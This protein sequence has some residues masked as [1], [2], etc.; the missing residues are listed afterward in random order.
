MRLT[1]ILLFIGCLQVSA[2]VLAQTI[3]LSEK[4]TPLQKVFKHIEQQSGYVFFFDY[5][6]LDKARPVTLVIKNIP[7]TTAL[8]LVFSNQPLKYSIAGKNIVVQLKAAPP[9]KPGS[10]T[11]PPAKPSGINVHGHVMD[12]LA[13]P[14]A[15]ASVSVIGGGGTAGGGAKGGGS[16]KGG[17]GA[18]AWG[19][20]ASTDEN[21]DFT[22]VGVRDNASIAITYVGYEPRIIRLDGNHLPDIVLIQGGSQ[23][24]E[25]QLT[26]YGSTSKRL[27][28]GDI[29]T[30]SSEEIALSPVPTVLQSLQGR[31]PG[32]FI[33]QQTGQPNGAFGVLIRSQSTLDGGVPQSPLYVVD[34]VAYPADGHL[35]MLG[36]SQ[37]NSAAYPLRGGNALNY[38][39]PALIES[40]NVLKGPDA[41]AIYGSRG[42]YGVVIITTKKARPGPLRLNIDTYSGITE[43]GVT[44]KLLN[45]PQ[46]LALRREAF[47]NDGLAPGRLDADVNGVWDTTHYTNWQ[48]AL[49]GAKA[50]ITKSTIFYSA[51]SNNSSFLLGAGYSEQGNVQRDKGSVRI[52]GVNFSIRS[53]T[54][55]RKF[56]VTLSGSYTHNVDDM[57]L[58]DASPS[59]AAGLLNSSGTLTA[60]DAPPLYLP[61]GSLDWSA[62]SNPDPG[63][64]IIYKNTTN[65]L[66][67]NGA[68]VYAPAP[69]LSIDLNAGYTLLS[70]KELRAEPSTYFNP[71]TVFP[72]PYVAPSVASQ[73]VSEL[74]LYSSSIVTLD[75]HVSYKRRLGAQ[76]ILELTTGATLQ[77][78][79]DEAT[80]MIGTGFVSDALLYDPANALNDD[81]VTSHTETPT[82]YLG[83]FGVAHYNWD[84]KYILNLNGR[85]DGSTK[86]SPVN[87]FGNFGSIGAAW[88]LSEEKWFKNLRRVADFVKLRGSWGVMGG[89]AIPNYGA[90]NTYT[91]GLNTYQGGIAAL[92]QYPA[93]PA[94]QWQNNREAELGVVIDVF[95]GAVNLGATYYTKRASNLLA[96]TPLSSVTGFTF[97]TENDAASVRSTGLEL[98]GRTKNIHIK[99]FS[100]ET[101]VNIT[102]PH[103][104]LLSFPGGN[105]GIDAT[106]GPGFAIGRP[107]T[108]IGLYKY[109]GVDPATGKYFF[110]NARGV[111]GPFI[112]P[113]I[114]NVNEPNTDRTQYIDLAPKCYGGIGNTLRYK[115]FTLDFFF[116][117]TDRMALNYQ[118]QQLLQPGVFNLNV[119]T[120]ALKRWRKPG[121]KSNFPAATTGLGAFFS[122]GDFVYSTGAYSNATYARLANVNLAYHFTSHALQKSHLT[123][124]NIYLAGQNLL[125]VTRF[126]DL[127]P[128]NQGE[129][130]IGPLRIFTGGFNISF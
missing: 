44:P 63:V 125:T 126:P 21:G 58:Y 1:P 8:D 122:Q 109:D 67:A 119:P 70:A 47:T 101:Y 74:N 106:Y 112:F 78:R 30:V 124:M 84:N 105:A 104:K 98:T 89:D 65:D 23:L 14:L 123:A 5:A 55:D 71:G 6:L 4:N 81:E 40:V 42:A 39:D 59:T 95:K 72:P 41:T 3:S 24:D 50:P 52:G 12:S 79:M 68:L 90:L 31:V 77:S 34:G 111:T 121:D 16:A 69:G 36:A 33:T 2:R 35:P 116:T 29:T 62:G 17:G 86:F 127:D 56:S 54:D 120:E 73:T 25:V 48:K 53:E 15:G 37:Q 115:Q 93:N 100:W 82:R 27:S 117:F 114:L 19:Q 66:V 13:H 83:F 102:F 46:Y 108:V 28:T 26:A 88:I 107:I 118:G 20:T 99:N 64:N 51:G 129:G 38:L 57:A 45:T 94:L 9:G 92:T 103:S 76:G 7:L 130:T 87:Q 43:T 113:A 75:P 49:Q 61:D 60:P 80:Y 22:L 85:R 10:L 32:L 11:E 110:T 97:V 18:A 128:E 96:L 91:I